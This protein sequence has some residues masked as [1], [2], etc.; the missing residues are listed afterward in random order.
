MSPEFAE[1]KKYGGMA[2]NSPDFPLAK[3]IFLG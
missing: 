2:M 3:K 1:N